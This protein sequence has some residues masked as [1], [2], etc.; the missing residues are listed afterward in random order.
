MTERKLRIGDVYLEPDGWGRV[1]TGADSNGV[2]D[3]KIVTWQYLRQSS[4]FI[5]HSY[6]R[7]SDVKV[8]K[9]WVFLFNLRD[10]FYD[11]SKG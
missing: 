1:L 4:L 8:G 3:D 5:G 2:G 9:D 6:G 11:A 7:L 10:L